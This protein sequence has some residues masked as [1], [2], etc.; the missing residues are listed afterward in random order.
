M[1]LLKNAWRGITRAKGR[2]VLIGLIVF[3]IAVSSCIAL[4]IRQAADSA[5]KSGLENMQ[6]TAQISVDREAMMKSAESSGGTMKGA[7]TAMPELSLSEMQTYAKSQYVKSFLYTISSSMDASGGLQAVDGSGTDSGGSTD[8]DTAK[9][10]GKSQGMPGGG[11]MGTQGDFTLIGYSSR[12]AM[13]AFISGTCK[14]TDGAMFDASDTGANCIVSSEL[15]TL[16]SLNVGGS[17]T[18]QNPNNTE[19]TVTLKVVGIY[20][21]SSSS[22]GGE[23][24]FDPG[25]DPANQILMNY[26]ALKAVVDAS[27]KNA[28][29]STNS[30]TGRV[31]STALRSKT[32]GTYVFQDAGHYEAFQKDVKSMGLSEEFV[33]S[34]GDLERYEQGLVPLQNLSRFAT[35]FFVI[36]LVAGGMILVALNL[37]HIRERKYEIGVLTAIGMKKRKVACQLLTE[38][39]IVTFAAILLGTG[40]GAAASVPAANALLST[41]ISSQQEA[42]TQRQQNFGG[43]EGGAS[44]KGQPGGEKEGAG[45]GGLQKAV[46][47]VSEVSSATNWTVVLELLAV[48]L[49]LALLSG[50]AAAISVLR[51]DPLKILSSRS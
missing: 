6:I 43:Q 28:V 48:G 31:T 1:Y 19:E 49:L 2:N 25:S 7:L 41:Q 3:V 42:Q 9:Q 10:D 47:Y 35:W 15:A 38:L 23:L 22:Q 26:N 12:D 45:P 24:R 39:L 46:N 8:T 27:E 16:N 13:T 29:T 18:L 4:S 44:S 34:S 5:K 33:I 32:A 17:I 20:T 37:F 50:G 11:R 14:L 21:N 36:V 30:A 40:V 51:Y